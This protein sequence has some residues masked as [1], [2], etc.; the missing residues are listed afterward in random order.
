MLDWKLGLTAEI[1][2]YQRQPATD[3]QFSDQKLDLI[4]AGCKTF[5]KEHLL[6]KISRDNCST[7]ISYVMAIQTETNVSE[8]Y[9]FDN[10]Y[11]LKQL[12]EY[13]NPKTLQRDD[14]TGYTRLLG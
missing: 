8:R 9:R 1:Q 14:K 7:I 11:K 13:H 6:T 2:P 3:D 5:L 4:T 12:A 10:I